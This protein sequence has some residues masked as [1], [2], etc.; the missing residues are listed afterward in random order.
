[1]Y[2]GSAS[3]RCL[4]DRAGRPAVHRFG[5]ARA[6][7]SEGR[8]RPHDLSRPTLGVR[9]A[10]T[11][12]QRT[13]FTQ[14]AE[15]ASL[16]LAIGGAFSHL[17]AARILGLP[18]LEGP[19]TACPVRRRWQASTTGEPRAIGSGANPALARYRSRAP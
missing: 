15:A 3:C 14:P 13:E 10:G 19:D 17:T 5:G 9:Q 12:P 2:A 4:A 18:T 8:L 11:D 1:M 7:A 16:V 6:G